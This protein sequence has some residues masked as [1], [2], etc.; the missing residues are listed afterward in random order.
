MLLNRLRRITTDGR[1]IPEIDGLRFVAIASVFLFHL[2]AELEV[3]S[4]R[5]IPIESKF[6]IFERFLGN[7][8]SGVDVFFVI[9]GMIL[10]MPFARQF[11]RGASPV[12][13]P[14]YYLRRLTRLE[15]PYIVSL[16]VVVLLTGIY[17][18]G[19]GA[20]YGAHAL[21]TLFYQHTLIYGQ[22][23]SVNPVTWSL[24]VEIQFYLL[25]PLAMQ[26]FRIRPT[27]LRR[28]LMIVAI[29]GMG[30]LQMPFTGS[31]FRLTASILFYMQ[32]FLAGLLVA[33][34][35]V[36]DLEG[37]R[38]SA[39][40]DILG[41]VSLAAIFWVRHNDARTHI[42]L[43]V[44]IGL[45]CIAAMRSVALRRVLA[46]PAIAVTGGMCY[47]IYLL[48]FIFIA[49][50][51]KVTRGAIVPSFSFPANYAIQLMVTGIPAAAMCIVFFLLV[52]RPCMD[53]NW[54]SKLW[55]RLTTRPARDPDAGR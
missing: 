38:S 47:S 23:S 28:G 20:D 11:L 51:F 1:W 40:W 33:D 15:P 42:V 48:H 24:E 21:A 22:M 9:S 31:S 52:E 32:Y 34:F 29:I 8:K 53:P 16:A 26:L 41:L 17:R 7:G 39:I 6:W 36:L 10:A 27:A 2:A 14:K 25:A 45:L 30:F 18:H 5:F 37:I 4:G 46:Y 50:L 55:N 44:L 19:L 13:L 43:P 49:V 12:S 35:F 3:R 54:P